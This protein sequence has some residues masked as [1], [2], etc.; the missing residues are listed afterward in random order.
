MQDQV[1]SGQ[2]DSNSRRPVRVHYLDSLRVLAV[3]M[4]FWFH[5]ATP[6]TVADWQVNNAQT[7]MAATVFFM[8]FLAPWGM[9]FFFLL[10][11]AGAWFALRRRT[12]RQ[13]AGERVRRLL[14]PFLVGSALI[15]PL[16][17]YIEWMF[18]SDIAKDYAGS[19]LQFLFVERFGGWN[20]TLFGWLGYHLWFLGFLF[21]FSLIA[22]P[23]FEWL[24]GEAG[25][26]IISWLARLCEHRGGVLVFIL[27]LVLIQ[28]GLRPFFPDEHNWA[29]YLFCLVCFLAGYL[30]YTDERFLR[31]VRR[32]R[33]LVL[34]VGIV[35]LLGLAALLALGEA[36]SLFDPSEPWFYAIWVMVPIDAWC[37]SLFMLFVGMRFLD[38]SNKWLQYGQEAV[39]P[40][41]VLHYPVL[42]II[43]FYVVQWQASVT[44]KMLAVSLGSFVVTL[45]I[46]E[47][48]IRQVTPLRAMFGMKAVTKPRTAQPQ[49]AAPSQP[50]DGSPVSIHGHRPDERGRKKHAKGS[51][52]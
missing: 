37:W 23:L 40:F 42:L 2:T 31:A 20:P 24:K 19:Y 39:M 14:V 29:D 30:F 34:A 8:V 46:Y 3:F 52:P 4:V 44:V 28:R 17:A 25:R 7:S 33:W 49:G 21:T 45:G 12:A 1:V 22:L 16:Q 13:F 10:A 41:Y 15:T 51:S 43:A 9:P 35:A 5:A 18:R 47:L 6:F 26:R 11:G 27:P 36:T 50:Q 32:D 38:F 48:L